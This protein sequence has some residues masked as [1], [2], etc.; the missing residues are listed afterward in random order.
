MYERSALILDADDRPLAK[1]SESLFVLGHR[2]QRAENVDELVRLAS[3]RPAHV[4]ALLLPAAY[5][6][7]WW[8]RVR[9]R[10]IEPIGLAPRSVLPVG[11]RLAQAN[12]Q[13]LHGDGLRWALWEP[14]SVWELR[15]AVSLVLSV[16]DPNETRLE[17]RV[18]CSIGVEARSQRRAISARLTDLSTGGAFVQTDQPLPVGTPIVLSAGLG[19]R[20]VSL[21]AIVAWRT[22]SHSPNWCDPGM[23]IEFERIDL[24]TLNLL[25]REMAGSLDRFRLCAGP[26]RELPA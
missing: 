3:E 1:V 13:S 15:F 4:G 2:P 5:A 11:A 16:S 10:F 17:M 9:E 7:D 18:P 21:H 24:A 19:G 8:P 22:G 25:R 14:F 26:I 12:S 6:C 20:P 23:G